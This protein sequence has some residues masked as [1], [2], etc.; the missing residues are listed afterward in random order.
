MVSHMR[1][2]GARRAITEPSIA[3]VILFFYVSVFPLRGI[4]VAASHLSDIEFVHGTQ[5]YSEVASLLALAGVAT[6]VLIE[7]FHRT[8]RRRPLST[9][10]SETVGTS[11]LSGL[12]VLAGL[13]SALTLI[14]LLGLIV[15]HHGIAGAKSAYVSHS[16]LAGLRGEHDIALSI[17][18]VLTLPTVWTAACVVLASGAKKVHRV[19]FATVATLIVLA[20]LI[21]FGSRLDVILAVVGVWIIFYYSGRRVPVLAVFAAITVIILVSV[22]ILEQRSSG[23]AASS[24]PLE[25]YSRIAGYGVLDATL[26]VRED[27]NEIRSKL[28]QSSRWLALPLYL[29]PSILWPGR[30]NINLT[31]MDLYVAESIGSQNQKTAGYPTTYMTELWLYGGWLL[32][33]VGSLVFGLVLGWFHER[34]IGRQTQLSPAMLLWYCLIADLG[35][36][37]YKDGDIVTSSVTAVRTGLYYAVALILTGVW[38]P[39]FGTRRENPARQ[40]IS[41][42]SVYH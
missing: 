10:I 37:Y 42:Q 35:F 41:Y 31:R 4:M 16:K 30:P 9:T 18:T 3:T 8:R 2:V 33:I 6:T 40:G 11:K 5:S 15:Q 36:T 20:D 19:T 38:K 14:S 34:I 25:K 26:A 29:T 32:V 1:W 7:A 39:K 22:P 12:V 24:S 13:T 28:E 27:P 17:W 21:I 23:S